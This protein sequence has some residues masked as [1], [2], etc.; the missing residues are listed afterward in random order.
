MARENVK[1]GSW[2][3]HVVHL[4]TIKQLS[5]WTP[6]SLIKRS[7]SI[8]RR[9]SSPRRSSLAPEAP[10]DSSVSQRNGDGDADAPDHPADAD[11]YE[12][13]EVK[14][15]LMQLLSGCYHEESRRKQNRRKPR[16]SETRASGG[17]SAEESRS[18]ASSRSTLTP[19]LTSGSSEEEP[20]EEEDEASDSELSLLGVSDHS[21]HHGEHS[22]DTSSPDDTSTTDSDTQNGSSSTAKHERHGRHP[23][24]D[25]EDAN[26]LNLAETKVL[27]PHTVE[28]LT[29]EPDSSSESDKTAPESIHTLAFVNSKAGPWPSEHGEEQLLASVPAVQCR[30]VMIK[31]T[32]FLT[33]KRFVF[34]AWIALD[35]QEDE[36][37]VLQEGVLTFIYPQ[38]WKA[39][40]RVYCVLSPYGVASYA[41]ASD[42][43]HPRSARS[44]S[45]FKEVTMDPDNPLRFKVEELTGEYRWVQTDTPEHTRQWYNAMQAALFR[46]RYRSDHVV[47]SVPLSRVE[48]YK[49]DDIMDVSFASLAFVI[50][51]Y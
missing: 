39:N 38:K 11:E 16:R 22:P 36:T 29:Q 14:E 7:G 6:Q 8:S 20:D 35:R 30:S 25:I 2:T 34:Y 28:V 9:D 4:P 18:S 31:G 19:A 15:S 47:L 21:R 45:A 1:K 24:K 46:Y 37:T 40:R 42:R 32:L 49:Y 13:G 33:N 50:K 51:Q 41:S 48:S 10:R 12:Q 44:L 26:D 23:L 5:A 27:L 43:L 3:S 17:S